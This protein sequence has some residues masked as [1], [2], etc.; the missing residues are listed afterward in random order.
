MSGFAEWVAH[1][2]KQRQAAEATQRRR[3]RAYAEA[4]TSTERTYQPGDVFQITPEHK[5][6]GWVGCY[7]YATAIKN[8]GI[9]GFVAWPKTHTQQAQAFIRLLWSEIAFV[10]SSPYRSEE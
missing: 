7:V 4:Y 3:G 8:F 2:R 10:E 1:K 6:A 5:M 9:Q